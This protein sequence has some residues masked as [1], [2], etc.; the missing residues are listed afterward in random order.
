MECRQESAILEFSCLGWIRC[1]AGEGV[2]LNGPALGQGV[3]KCR[4]DKLLAAMELA[5][6]DICFFAQV[7]LFFR[8]PAKAVVQEPD[9]GQNFLQT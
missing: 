1:E 6:E 5:R 4:P 9:V 2:E 7:D 8:Q 3:A